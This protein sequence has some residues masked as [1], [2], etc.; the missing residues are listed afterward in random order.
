MV[1]TMLAFFNEDIMKT[2]IA[3]G[4]CLL[5]T[6]SASGSD[7]VGIGTGI[8]KEEAKQKALENLASNFIIDIHSRVT[9]T[10]EIIGSEIKTSVDIFIESS[11]NLKLK[12]LTITFNK[13]LNGTI[14][15]RAFISCHD[16]L[17]IHIDE[18]NKIHE[19]IRI[20][21]A[22]T[23]K[24]A[25]QR[26]YF[27]AIDGCNE[28]LALIKE[29]EDIEDIFFVGNIKCKTGYEMKKIS[30]I[31]KT[32]IEACRDM[33]NQ[34][35]PKFELMTRN[36]YKIP[37]SFSNTYSFKID[38]FPITN[39]QF[40]AFLD[41][42]PKWQKRNIDSKYHDGNYLKRWHLNEYPSREQN[43]PVTHVS[44]YAATAYCKWVQ[45]RLPKKS[46]WKEAKSRHKLKY[47][48]LDLGEWAY[49]KPP[50]TRIKPGI[51]AS[52][53]MDSVGNGIGFRCVIKD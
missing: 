3:F 15:A 12:G 43:R 36:T 16:L 1:L 45:L 14:E 32:E 37:F 52:S 47:K 51:T 26:R 46:E 6:L 30:H 53:T 41:L 35:K 39:A 44:W 8:N 50:I 48:D 24:A 31:W 13:Q 49:E 9:T 38:Q 4:L 33:L 2:I 40:K 18:A 19:H 27:D 11:S 7:F 17:F 23:K 21:L 29:L 34:F 10:E 22:N 20:L 28:L 42:N 5:F 25:E